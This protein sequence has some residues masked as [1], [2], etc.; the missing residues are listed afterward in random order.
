[1]VVGGGGIVREGSRSVVT[2]VG[3]LVTVVWRG[4]RGTPGEAQC[5]AHPAGVRGVNQDR[6]VGAGGRHGGT[7]H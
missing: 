5:G 6:R 3:Q 4:G 2:R 7:H 1:M